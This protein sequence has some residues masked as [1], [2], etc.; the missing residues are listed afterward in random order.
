MKKWLILYKKY[1]LLILFILCIFSMGL[2]N[3][4][5]FYTS[6]KS[7]TNTTEIENT[8]NNNFW[9]RLSFVDIQGLISYLTGQQILNGVIKG[10]DGKLNLQ[11][12]L[13]YKF[14]EQEE[15]SKT[16]RAI[17]ILKHA[18][19]KKAKVLYVQRPWSTD[20]LPYG[21]KFELDEQFDYWCD[22]MDQA[23]FP[24]V[25]LRTSIKNNLKF[26]KTDHHWTIE[27]SFYANQF[28]IDTLNQVYN[29]KLDSEKVHTNI[30]NYQNKKYPDSFLGSEG[31]R[32][33]KYFSGKDDFELI[34]PEFPTN[35][36]YTQF[37]NHRQSWKAAGSYDDVFVDWEK[38]NDPNYNNKYN[39]ITYD[40][41][42]EN[43]IINHNA[44]NNLKVMLIADSFARP[45]VTYLA[46]DFKETRYLDP[47]E[48]RYTDS[49]IEYI[50]N[51]QPDVVIMMFAGDGTFQNI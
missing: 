36:T 40:G 43:R 27:S 32:T 7:S 9:N 49:Y 35:F 18:E 19:E 39:T 5:N 10:T 28:I 46:N 24:V 3:M 2:L 51:Y 41:Y 1:V 13:N 29:L 31:I 15:S 21:Y 11:D 48:G 44:E 23:G 30:E 4:S 22:S 8:Y 50:D 6:S 12:N 34:L 47:Q 16:K 42:I 37:R 14:I 26:Y 20:C 17:S 45:M 38:V 33:G 25:D